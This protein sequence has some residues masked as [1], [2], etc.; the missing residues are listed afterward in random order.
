MNAGFMLPEDWNP[1]Y[2]LLDCSKKVHTDMNVMKTR[3]VFLC[4][5]T[6]M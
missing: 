4:S 1:S 6:K 2:R 3:N 5:V